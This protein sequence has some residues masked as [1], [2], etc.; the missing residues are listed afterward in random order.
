MDLVSVVKFDDAGDVIPY[1]IPYFYFKDSDNTN[2]NFIFSYNET[3][4]PDTLHLPV[5]INYEIP[6]SSGEFQTDITI[7]TEVTRILNSIELTAVYT[8][9]GG[10]NQ[11]E[12]TTS[13]TGGVFFAN[14]NPATYQ[15]IL[16]INCEVT[17]TQGSIPSEFNIFTVNNSSILPNPS[18]YDQLIC[19]AIA[20]AKVAAFVLPIKVNIVAFLPSL[21]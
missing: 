15:H 18:N 10:I 12:I 13:S 19:T 6:L 2:Y 20:P 8:T 16:G 3:V 7:I 9:P 14:K 21:T 1:T 4:N 5:G 17:V 11:L